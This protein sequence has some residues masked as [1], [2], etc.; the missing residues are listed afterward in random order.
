MTDKPQRKTPLKN[1]LQFLT[2]ALLGVLVLLYPM[3]ANWFSQYNQSDLLGQYSIEVDQTTQAERDAVL[4]SAREY[5]AGLN[6]GGAFDPF[7]QG[8]AGLDSQPYQEYLR[9]LEGVPTG[10]M[11]RVVI[12]EINV[13]MP[14]YHGTTEETLLKG[15]GHLYGTALPVGGE[16]T[17][18]VITAHSGLANHRMFTDLPDL[19]PGDIFTI[20]TYGEQ[21]H[22]EVI[23]IDAVLPNETETLVPETSRDLLTLVTCTP[24][25]V[26]SHRMLVT[27]QRTEIEEPAEFP[28]ESEVPGFPWWAVILGAALLGAIGYV[29]RSNRGGRKT[30]TATEDPLARLEA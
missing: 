10:V 12:P 11:G 3:T 23:T 28:M 20:E 27:G 25:G 26:N 17:H 6:A 5:N 16:G 21:L 29:W 1:Q 8:L 30:A 24:I 22:Y 4:H 2:V 18:S 13:D 14:I 19:V 9:E 15:V 7:T